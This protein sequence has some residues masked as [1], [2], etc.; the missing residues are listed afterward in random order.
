MNW[1]DLSLTLKLRIPLAVI[2]VLLV[3]LSILQ[4]NTLSGV[5]T[6]SELINGTYTPALNKVLNAD[7]DL[8]QAQIAERTLAFGGSYEGLKASHKENLDQVYDRLNAVI[9]MQ[10][11][12]KTRVQAEAFLAAF[13]KWRP[14]SE[15]LVADVTSGRISYEQAEALSTGTLEK[16]FES[17][18]EILD[19][20]GEN[21][22][23]SAAALHS[24][25]VMLNKSARNNLLILTGL[26]VAIIIAV[27]VLLPP[28]L[29][30]PIKRTTWAL[31]KLA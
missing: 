15:K 18:R 16:E 10:V 27:I 31:D 25:G 3:I 17:A 19:T 23:E 28:L 7:R 29:T 11:N 14:K 6:T 20:V 30:R 8:Y 12:D 13:A 26:S 1:R 24:D 2:G 22:S 4:L 5:T 21:L 9:N